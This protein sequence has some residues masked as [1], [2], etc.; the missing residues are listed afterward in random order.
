M[1][2]VMLM[3]WTVLIV[4]FIF[5]EAMT[6]QLVSIWFALGA[7]SAGVASLFSAS[8]RIQWIIFVAITIITLCATRPIVRKLL[9]KGANPTNADRNIGKSAVVTEEIDNINGRGQVRING[10]TW[11][12]RSCD[13]TIYPVDQIVTV[14]RIEGVKLIVKSCEKEHF[15]TPPIT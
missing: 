13:G 4:F 1:Q 14:D 3:F 10:A 12:A 15:E 5:V 2:T 8:V 6:A 9:K 7:L 11:T